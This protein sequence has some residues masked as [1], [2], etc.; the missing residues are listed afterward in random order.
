MRDNDAG[1]RVGRM[2]TPIY[3]FV[4]RYA[5]SDTARLHMP[6]HK[7]KCFLGCEKYDITEIDGADVL[8]RAEG[9]IQESEDN[10][11]ALFSTHH[12]FYSAEGSTLAIKAMLKL[13]ADNRKEDC[14][15]VILA[16]RNAHRAFVNACAFLD[17]DVC[18]IYPEENSHLCRCKVTKESVE[19]ALRGMETRPMAVYITSPD[20]L[21]NISD[22]AAIAEAC[23]NFDIPLLVDNAH[24]AYLEFLEPSRHPIALG[25]AMCADSAHK[26]L[27]VLTG[28]AYLHISKE[29]DEYAKG[30]RSALSLFAS[31]SPSYLI[32][33]S[34]DLCNAYLSEGYKARLAE[35]IRKIE[36]LK[37]KLSHLGY[38]TE[39]S[40]PL[41]IVFHA[42]R[43]GYTGTELAYHLRSH[44][45]E[46]EFSDTEYTVLM[47][48]PENDDADFLRVS[49]AMK[50]LSPRS[51]KLTKKRYF[52]EI[53]RLKKK[54][55]IR[56]AVLTAH[57]FVPAD[58]SVGRICGAPTVSCPPA[59]PIAI[60]GELID[61]RTAELFRLYG[62]D[63]IEVVK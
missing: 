42:Q 13:A 50:R 41:K 63:K 19:Q 4:T 60:S 39:M 44:G 52:P 34:L 3:D 40:E 36:E 48:T 30:A 37:K 2:K 46:A 49:E 47:A 20:Y 9:I 12:T 8:Y 6:G 25:A 11:S 55:S 33:Q 14:A 27:P 5:Q 16:T 28:G 1:R 62:I 56:A 23:K 53:S 24:G 31:T 59:V 10:T 35:C 17:I 18:W 32:L 51:N 29:Y 7:G 58:E 43:F 38:D 26:T 54:M 22:I 21:G 45:I 15:K 61:E 57:E